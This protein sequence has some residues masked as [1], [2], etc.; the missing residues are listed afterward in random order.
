MTI[1]ELAAMVAPYEPAAF[2][3]LLQ[4]LDADSY[5]SRYRA[6]V[7]NL[8]AY[9]QAMNAEIEA[10]IQRREAFIQAREQYKRDLAAGKAAVPPTDD[11]GDESP[12]PPLPV[13]PGA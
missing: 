1:D 12:L 4:T 3:A 10:R 2:G 7:A 8:R 11:L 9:Q 13:A 6:Q 5:L